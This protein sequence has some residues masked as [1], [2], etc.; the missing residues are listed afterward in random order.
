MAAWIASAR[1]MVC[2]KGL[3]GHSCGAGMGVGGPSAGEKTKKPA[4]PA[5]CRICQAKRS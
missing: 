2:S 4:M 5:F 3:K 1:D